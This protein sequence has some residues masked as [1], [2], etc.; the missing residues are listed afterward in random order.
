MEPD[1]AL[2]TEELRWVEAEEPN[3]FAVP[4][5]AVFRMHGAPGLYKLQQRWFIPGPGAAPDREEWRDVP[6]GKE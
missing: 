1:I 3:I 6:V 4:A 5:T 2:A